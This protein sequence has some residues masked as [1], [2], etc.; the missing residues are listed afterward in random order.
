ML[1]D[2]ANFDTSRR[3]NRFGFLSAQKW[4]YERGLCHMEIQFLHKNLTE[5]DPKLLMDH[6]KKMASREA[7]FFA[8]TLSLVF[9]KLVE[10]TSPRPVPSGFS[11]GGSS[12]TSV[13]ASSP[14][15]TGFSFK[16]PPTFVP[17]SGTTPSN[18]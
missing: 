14:A 15:P 3:E 5:K 10:K 8:T 4:C 7:P 6:I 12:G 16:F 18:P 13:T 17:A 9:D 2:D 11:F 1:L